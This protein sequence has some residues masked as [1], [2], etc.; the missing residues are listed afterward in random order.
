[1][2]VIW[3]AYQSEAKAIAFANK[4]KTQH[5]VDLSIEFH[6]GIWMVGA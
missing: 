5:N 1:M 4:I 2:S 6:G 3:K